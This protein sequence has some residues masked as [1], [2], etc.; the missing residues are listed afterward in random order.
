MRLPTRYTFILFL[1]IGQLIGVLASPIHELTAIE[2]PQENTKFEERS[3]TLFVQ[4]NPVRS[5]SLEFEELCKENNIY[6]LCMPAFKTAYNRSFTSA[7]ICSAFRGAGLVPLQ[8]DTVL[9]KLD[10]QLRTPTP[11]ALP[12]AP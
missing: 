10:V 5:Y 12:E 11:A 8:P 3:S 2:H 6:N 4:L 7:N 1:A 9:S